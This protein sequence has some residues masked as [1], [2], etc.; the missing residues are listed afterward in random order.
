MHLSNGKIAQVV[1]VNPDDPRFPIVQVHGEI[2]RNGKPIIHS[3]SADEIFITRALSVKE[4][5]L[6]LQEGGD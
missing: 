1:D 2:H 6:I 5:R 3:T 4:Q